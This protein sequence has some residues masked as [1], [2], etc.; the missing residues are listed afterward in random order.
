MSCVMFEE[1]PG[2]DNA[3]AEAVQWGKELVWGSPRLRRVG[4]ETGVMAGSGVGG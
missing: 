4:D 2:R 1:V 3:S